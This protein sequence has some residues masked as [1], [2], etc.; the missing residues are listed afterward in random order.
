MI[1]MPDESCRSCGGELTPYTK[2]AECNQV[3]R[4][5]CKKCGTKT[6]EQFHSSCMYFIE[7]NLTSMNSIAV[8]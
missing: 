5:I 6:H 4:S 1:K 7:N 3:N 2:C 8:C